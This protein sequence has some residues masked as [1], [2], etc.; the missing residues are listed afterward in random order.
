M[1]APEPETVRILFIDGPLEGETRNLPRPTS[2]YY[3]VDE[4]PREPI[5]KH[6]PVKM[7]DTFRRITGRYRVVLT[8]DY[9]AEAYY[10][11]RS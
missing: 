2:P 6:A 10:E 7:G 4:T 11:G 5:P 9:N 8:G 1:D 3:F